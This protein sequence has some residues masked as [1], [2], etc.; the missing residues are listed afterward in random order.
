M[1]EIKELQ[2]AAPCPA[3]G[4]PKPKAD[5]TYRMVGALVIVAILG[6]IVWWAHEKL[7]ISRTGLLSESITRTGDTWLAD[8]TAMIPAPESDVYSAI[9]H[10]E[11][12]RSASIQSV[13]VLS[14][15]GN[16]KTVE[17][18]TAGPT[19]QTVPIELAFT[20]NPH[21]GII[22]FRSLNSP[23]LD[24]RGQYR[25]TAKSGGT[26][27]DFHQQLKL[28]PH[29]PVPNVLIKS[30]IRRFFVAQLDSVRLQLHLPAGYPSALAGGRLAIGGATIDVEFAPGRI[31]LP[32]A[33]LLGWVA[34]AA[35]AVTA[36]YGRFPVS[37]YRVI[38]FPV[39]GES[40]VLGGTSYGYDGAFSRLEVGEFVTRLQLSND[41]MMTHEMVH[42]A[43]PDMN[44]EHHWIEEGIATYVEPVARE[45]IGQLS[46]ATVWGELVDGLPKGLPQ[47]GDRGLDHTH[48]WGR[49]Y[50][51]GA[52]FCTLAD[53]QIR[54][55]THERY[56]LQDALRGILAA[57]GNMTVHWPIERALRGGDQA[58]GVPVLEELYDRMKAAPVD[59]DLGALWRQLGVGQRHGTVVFDNGAPLVSVRMAITPPLRMHNLSTKR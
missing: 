21:Q 36:Y 34:T 30:A 40:G 22:D 1:S 58:V 28:P 44:R 47:P 25:L 11:R 39:E 32:R 50:W 56:G 38:I 59:V 29:L 18:M 5:L 53:V 9:E 4:S 13:R 43:F 33:V 17:M 3:P 54:E 8:F 55:R 26:L 14:Q 42:L 6:L 48:T 7:T 35:Q 27:I 51:G 10:V 52:L 46:A 45:E 15:T 12:V 16:T 31:D 37:R 24:T 19:G 41:W 23:F 20:Y 2:A 57:G 49:T